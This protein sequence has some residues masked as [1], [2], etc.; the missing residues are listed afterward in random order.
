MGSWIWALKERFLQVG[1]Q[2]GLVLRGWHPYSESNTP[3][4]TEMHSTWDKS[5][6]IRW[7]WLGSM[8]LLWI[9]FGPLPNLHWIQAI[10]PS[11]SA[12]VL[13]MRL[14]KNGCQV[15]EELEVLIRSRHS[16]KDVLKCSC[17]SWISDNAV[18]VSIPGACWMC[19]GLMDA[20]ASGVFQ[21]LCMYMR[22]NLFT[23][24][25][26]GSVGRPTSP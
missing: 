9:P 5:V 11:T 13:R 12:H 23:W 14:G 6:P 17:A 18:D 2:F 24:W 26:V 15:Q 25:W 16:F 22:W 21:L 4:E 8:E 20:V 1:F 19:P 7:P 3:G 10:C